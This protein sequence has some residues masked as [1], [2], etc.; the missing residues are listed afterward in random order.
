MRNASSTL[1]SSRSNG[2]RVI[3]HPH[4]KLTV[5]EPC[6]ELRP[7][8]R[9]FLITESTSHYSHL[10]LPDTAP[11]AAFR[12]N[13]SSLRLGSDPL[14]RALL[15]GV[16]DVTRTLRR[17]A[18]TAVLLVRFTETGLAAFI[19]EPLHLLFD[20]SMSIDQF[21]RHSELELVEEQLAEA[22]HHVERIFIL[23]QFLLHRLPRHQVEPDPL[24][25]FL[26]K[27]IKQKNG[28]VRIG[29]L[30]RDSGLSQSAIERRFCRNVGTTPRKFAS[31]VRFRHVLELKS[32]ANNLTE[33]AY[34]AGYSDQ[35]HFI[36]DFRRFTAQPPRAFFQQR[37]FC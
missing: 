9:Q 32:R 31:I 6:V 28:D 17:P 19:R 12:F 36:N 15:S 24:V 22:S 33:V 23:E 25:Q 7:F 21:V 27:Q 2:S 1:L 4:V 10:L 20:V 8:V 34:R 5:A 37:S 29:D 30:V 11:V 18:N 3:A 14:P 35:S 26:V 16:Y 13:G